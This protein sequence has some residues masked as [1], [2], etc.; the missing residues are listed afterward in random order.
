MERAHTVG[1]RKN[2]VAR[3]FLSQGNGKITVNGRPVEEYFPVM[4]LQLKINKPFEAT[5]LTGKFDVVANVN[6]GGINGQ[7]IA[8]QHGISRALVETD[9]ELKPMLKKADLMTRD[10]RMVERKKYGQKKARKGFQFSKR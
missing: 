2:A 4:Q 1:R 8:I 9:E 3:V 5:E 7:A 10:P 6:G